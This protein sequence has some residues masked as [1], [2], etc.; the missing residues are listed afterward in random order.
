ML[1]FKCKSVAY[2]VGVLWGNAK[3]INKG[4]QKTYDN[5]GYRVIEAYG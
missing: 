3:F 1:G 5:V 2:F 4:S